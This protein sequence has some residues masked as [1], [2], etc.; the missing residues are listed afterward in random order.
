M[1]C[2][3][4]DQERMGILNMYDITSTLKLRDLYFA[5]VENLIQE[6]LEDSANY[7]EKYRQK[8]YNFWIFSLPVDEY[9]NKEGV[10]SFED[11]KKKLL[12]KKIDHDYFL[13]MS[14]FHDLSENNFY[15]PNCKYAFQQKNLLFKFYFDQF[16]KRHDEK[17]F[18]HNIILLLLL[19]FCKDSNKDKAGYFYKILSK[20]GQVTI[21]TFADYLRLYLETNI[22]GVFEKVM[23]LSQN[24]ENSN[25]YTFFL[26]EHKTELELE[27][28]SFVSEILGLYNLKD[29]NEEKVY[30]VDPGD[31]TSLFKNREFI[32]NFEEL[33]KYFLEKA[34]LKKRH[35]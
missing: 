32:F 35:Y 23:E 21:K 17:T 14:S 33:W 15:H 12:S 31:F 8:K 2:C 29:E 26:K 11:W 7:L 1:T 10:V 27:I 34:E 22:F 13:P 19:S 3:L 30:L 5:E 6:K 18:D 25:E 28:T 24:E 20:I 16:G 4:K 9:G